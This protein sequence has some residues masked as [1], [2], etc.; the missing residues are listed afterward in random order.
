MAKIVECVPNFSEGRRPEVVDAIVQAMTSVPGC[1][2][3]DKEMDADHN[4]C[5]VTIAG[6]PG[7]VKEGVFLGIKKATELIDL[8]THQGEHPRMGATDVVPFVPIADVT[9]DECKAM[10]AELAERVATELEIPVYLYDQAARRPERENL[11]NI[12]AGEFEGIR[13]E[14]GTN[15]AREP[16]FGPKRVHPTAGCMAV[17]ARMILVAFNVNLTTSDVD[18][19]KK[20]ARAVRGKSGGFQ[21]VR[22]LGFEIKE[23]NLAQVSMN[24]I[25]FKRSPVHRVF[26]FVKREAARYGV[27]VLESEIVGLVPQ[28]ALVKAADYYL[29]LFPAFKNDQII[30]NRLKS[31]QSEP[32]C[33]LQPFLDEV[34]SSK[35]APGGG[36]C[37]AAAG[38]T[39][40]ALVGMHCALTTTKKRF[41]DVKEELTTVRSKAEN[42]R[43]E[44]TDLIVTDAEA[45]DKM[46]AAMKMPKE[47]TE[48]KAVATEAATKNGIEVP[49]RTM[50]ACVETLRLAQV[51]LEKGN[52]NS[53]SDGGCGCLQALAGCQGAFYNVLINMPGLQDKAWGAQKRKEADDLLAEA[54][55]LAAAAETRVL[56]ELTKEG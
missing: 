1:N 29:Q 42:L 4:R 17:G 10:A 24:L 45:F 32:G 39:G 47:D 51:V 16:D 21:Y 41:A 44:L 8:N 7:P 46:M 27:G 11:A 52:P 34:A 18:I 38:A 28:E 40:A 31:I 55:R 19:A 20:I 14:I 33:S 5:V 15:P 53:L 12:R 37:S 35:P 48:A 3:L 26:E 49:L 2:L 36:S 43:K 50:R 56:G 22:G 54:K 23:R 30:E 6:E 13:E 9:M 25:N